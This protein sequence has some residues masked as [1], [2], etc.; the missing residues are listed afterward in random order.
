MA[1]KQY[2]QNRINLIEKMQEGKE[3]K[4]TVEELE[5]AY[6]YLSY[7]CNCGKKILPIEAYSHCFL[8]NSHKFGCSFFMRLIG[9]IYFFIIFPIKLTLALLILPFYLI[10]FIWELIKNK[11]NLHKN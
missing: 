9:F 1:N 8:G 7:C 2:L 5:S 11:L 4:P 10:Y 6:G 3:Y